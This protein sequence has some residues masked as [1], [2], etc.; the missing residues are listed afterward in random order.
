LEEWRSHSV[1]VEGAFTIVDDRFV[2]LSGA[3]RDGISGCSIDRSVENFKYFRDEL[4]LDALNR[5]LIH[6]RDT[7]G[8]IQVRDR[9]A[10][11]TELAAGRCGPETIVFDLAV[12]NLGDLRAGRFEIPL[13]ESWYARAFLTT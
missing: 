6:Y 7:D 1:D 2:I 13:A 8:A 12:Q 10:F 11:K 9:V 3:S 4:D 5:N